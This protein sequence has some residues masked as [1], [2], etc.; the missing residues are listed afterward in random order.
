MIDIQKV[1]ENRDK[2][3]KI[4]KSDKQTTFAEWKDALHPLLARSGYDIHFMPFHSDGYDVAHK[5]A[6]RINNPLEDRNLVVVLK[7]CA[8]HYQ[9][10]YWGLIMLSAHYNINSEKNKIIVLYNI[11]RVHE[12]FNRWERD[13][14][15]HE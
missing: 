10:K 11:S 9:Q 6:E 12:Y 5:I 14:G 15:Y 2:A 4:L 13:L 7:D 3:I 8:T 1:R